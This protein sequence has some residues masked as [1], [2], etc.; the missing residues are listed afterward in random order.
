MTNVIKKKSRNRNALVHGLYAKDVLLPWDSKEDF[1]RLHEDLKAEFCPHGRAEE[2][3]VLDLAF[4][5]LDKQTIRRMR[6]SAVL[7]DPFT[8]DIVQT[9]RKSWSGI[10]KR[11][12]AGAKDMRNL[13]NMAEEQ[14]SKFRLDVERLQRKLEQS[15]DREE[16][17]VLES[18]IAAS[19]HLM[20]EYLTPLLQQQ[21]PNAEQA[22]DNMYAPESM[23]KIVRLEAAIDA[24]LAKTMGRLIGLKEFKRTPA[25]GAAAHMIEVNPRT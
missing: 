25:G 5:H 21:G 17:K 9:Q 15:T 16:I 12:R 19:L 4:L 22:F 24:R 14:F 23:E 8:Q 13:Q 18:K 2:E 10:R 11:L 20:S 3:A 7:N 1:E 6:Q